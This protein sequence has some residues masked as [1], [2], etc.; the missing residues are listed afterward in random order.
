MNNIVE[1]LKQVAYTKEGK[2]NAAVLRQKWFKESELCKKVIDLTSFLDSDITFA[3]RVYCIENNISSTPLCP[4]SKVVLK[5]IP[6]KHKFAEVSGK[7]NICKVRNTKTPIWLD[8]IRRCRGTKKSLFNSLFDRGE[9]KLKTKKECIDFISTRL[10]DTDYGRSHNFVD[11]QILRDFHDICC[12]ILSYTQHP[13]LEGEKINW[14]ERFYLLINNIEPK[15]CDNDP[16]LKAKYSN[17]L[18][19]YNICSSRKNLQAKIYNDIQSSIISQGFTILNDV[20]NHETDE[21]QLS[22]NTCSNHLVRKLNNARW[23][24]IFCEKCAGITVGRSRAEQQIV[25]FI[26]QDLNLEVVCNNKTILSGKEIDIFVPSKQLGI[27]YHGLLWHSFGSGYPNNQEIENIKKYSHFQKAE[28]CRSHGIH[29][30]QIF[31][32]EWINK[33]DIVKSIIRTKLG[34]LQTKIF[35][36]KCKVEQVDNATKKVFLQQN[37]LQGNDN[38]QFA[39]ALKYED[40]IIA[41]MTFGSR[42]ITK[43]VTFELIRFCCRINT[44]VVGGASKLLK[45]FISNWE[46]S[47]ITSYADKRYCFDGSFYN[48]LGFKLIRSS[49]PNYWWTDTKRVMHRA[50]FQKY[51]LIEGGADASLTEREIMMARG[52]RRIWDCGHFVFE[53]TK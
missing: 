39:V 34:L 33:L 8:S 48:S 5:W 28:M 51:K 14:S 32:N 30:L 53:L 7:G 52:W 16:A 49:E 20:A 18:R 46:C 36:R 22:C 19:G 6:V 35:A 17:F 10:I 1:A 50:N 31:E 15:R 27:E 13:L 26:Q 44:S 12:S 37:H 3:A 29:L 47:T 9:Y 24:D 4:L 42:Q 38:S 45:F 25:E 43:K 11:T 21:Y 23:K 40:E 41:M 2:L